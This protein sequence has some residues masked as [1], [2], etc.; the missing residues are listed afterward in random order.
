MS[1]FIQLKV[2]RIAYARETVSFLQDQSLSMLGH[3]I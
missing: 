3:Q 2:P 1:Y